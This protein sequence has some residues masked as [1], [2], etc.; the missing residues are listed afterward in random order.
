MLHYGFSINCNPQTCHL[1][2]WDCVIPIKRHLWCTYLSVLLSWAFPLSVGASR[3]WPCHDRT[4]VSVLHVSQW[5]LMSTYT[6][7]ISPRKSFLENRSSQIYEYLHSLGLGIREKS[8]RF[9]LSGKLI[10]NEVLPQVRN[11]RKIHTRERSKSSIRKN[12]TWKFHCLQNLSG[13]IHTCQVYRF[14]YLPTANLLIYHNLPISLPS[15]RQPTD[16][17]QSTDFYRFFRGSTEF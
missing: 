3:M 7:F 4:E 13:N 17:P 16:L 14:L 10:V 6:I 2:M 12:Y 8:G 9:F 15:Y 5:P 11:L 1:T